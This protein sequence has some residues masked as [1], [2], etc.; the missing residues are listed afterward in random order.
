M[1]LARF[2]LSAA[3]EVL[4]QKILV[5]LLLFRLGRVRALLLAEAFDATNLE[6]KRE[7]ADE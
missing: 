1:P 5:L 3:L 6:E 2:I 4:M 7:H